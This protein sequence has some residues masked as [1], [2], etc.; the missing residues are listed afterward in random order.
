MSMPGKAPLEAVC[1][2]DAV[3]ADLDVL[4]SL[5]GSRAMHT[6]RL[7][8]AAKG[9]MHYLVAEVAGRVVGFGLIVY[10][11][12]LHWDRREHV[13]LLVNLHVTP[14]HRSQGA[15]SAIIAEMERRA[16]HR[17]FTQVYLCVDPKNNPRAKTLYSRLGYVPLQDKPFYDP[18]Q[19]VH[20]DGTIEE[21][22]E[23]NIEMVKQL[24]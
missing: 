3:P 2:R 18:Y 5:H 19:F 10:E 17:G 1:I 12:P 22:V 13:P 6:D 9:W 14:E 11:A 7:Q 8:E 16:R 24:K 4:P 21:G 23:W 15:G 20:S